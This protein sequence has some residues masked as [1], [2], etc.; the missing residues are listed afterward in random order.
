MWF[1]KSQLYIS[2]YKYPIDL[3]YTPSEFIFDY[4]YIY[5]Y[6]YQHVHQIAYYDIFAKFGP[7][8]KLFSIE[9]ELHITTIKI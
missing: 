8:N 5:I 3:H 1:F 9:Y 4:I 2:S 7:L 6:I